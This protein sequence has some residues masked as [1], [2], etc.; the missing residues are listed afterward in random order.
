MS[1]PLS[2]S[3]TTQVD[4]KDILMVSPHLGEVTWQGHSYPGIVIIA[5][6]FG[7]YDAAIVFCIDAHLCQH[8]DV[9]FAPC[10]S[11]EVLDEEKSQKRGGFGDRKGD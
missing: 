11:G 1:S 5:T 9:W 10:G 6:I 8:T 2:S 4:G 3:V 7:E